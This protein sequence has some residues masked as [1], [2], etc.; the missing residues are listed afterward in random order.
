MTLAAGSKLGLCE[1]LGQ[2]GA[3]GM[4]EVY[5]F[6]TPDL[7]SHA[8]RVTNSATSDLYLVEGWK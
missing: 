7:S 5:R 8:N 4:G 3:G 2:T 6:V 1:I